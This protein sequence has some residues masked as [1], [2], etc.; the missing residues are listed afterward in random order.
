MEI[1]NEIGQKIR[2]C[3]VYD[4]IIRHFVMQQFRM[5]KFKAGWDTN[6]IP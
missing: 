1:G 3:F 4:K 6:V 2:V 5:L